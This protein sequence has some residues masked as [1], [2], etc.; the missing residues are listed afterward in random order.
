M[1]KTAATLM[2]EE[3]GR[4]HV[5]GAQAQIEGVASAS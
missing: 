2:A 1:C 3:A 4:Q 5:W